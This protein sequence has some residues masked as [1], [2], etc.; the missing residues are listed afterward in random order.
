MDAV[1]EKLSLHPRVWK[2]T[3]VSQVSVFNGYWMIFSIA[4]T[5]KK[6]R[7]N[8]S[9]KKLMI[10]DSSFVLEYQFISTFGLSAFNI[11]KLYIHKCISIQRICIFQHYRMSG[12]SEI[13]SNG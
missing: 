10:K 2:A 7:A 12:R 1:S 5:K 13:V 8:I 11:Q 4:F 6:F 3:L 9:T